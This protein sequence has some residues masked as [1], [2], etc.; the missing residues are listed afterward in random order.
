MPEPVIP[1]N[2]QNS[3][4]ALVHFTTRAVPDRKIVER[5]EEGRAKRRGARG[6][7]RRGSNGERRGW[8]GRGGRWG[9]RR[10]EARRTAALES[11]AVRVGDGGGGVC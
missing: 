10:P 2:L 9:G 1:A 3:E 8:R 6:G 5:G 4:H 7:E 11:L